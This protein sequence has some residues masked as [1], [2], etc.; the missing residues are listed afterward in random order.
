MA[1]FLIRGKRE[2][3][4]IWYSAREYITYIYMWLILIKNKSLTGRSL[5][6]T[7]LILTKNWTQVTF[8]GIKPYTTKIFIDSV[9][10]VWT[11]K[12]RL[13]INHEYE[14]R[15]LQ[16]NWV[17]ILVKNAAC[18]ILAAYAMIHVRL[19]LKCTKFS[20]SLF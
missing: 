17:V 5:L 11:K 3:F 2:N 6:Q 4:L 15:S 14:R 20:F 12:I 9:N 19:G 13:L 10:T 7:A 8:S 16:N 18:S 1:S